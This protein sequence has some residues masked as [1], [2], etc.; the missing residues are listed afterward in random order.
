MT[1]DSPDKVRTC[2]DCGV[3]LEP[4]R[5]LDATHP[6]FDGQGAVQVDLKYASPDARLSFWTSKIPVAGLVQGMACP[7]CGLIQLYAVKKP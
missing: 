4:I 5:L 6:G 1:T 3:E 7:Q 2:H